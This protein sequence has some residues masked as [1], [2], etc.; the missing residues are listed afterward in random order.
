MLRLNLIS[1]RVKPHVFVN[2]DKD[3]LAPRSLIE[4]REMRQQK[5]FQENVIQP[6][7]QTSIVFK[8]H[9]GEEKRDLNSKSGAEAEKPLSQCEPFPPGIHNSKM[10]ISQENH[11]NGEDMS[12]LEIERKDADVV[13]KK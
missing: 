1:G 3:Q 6:S 8:N 9:K 2:F 7:D 4:K 12:I 10:G 5:Y 11:H 13:P